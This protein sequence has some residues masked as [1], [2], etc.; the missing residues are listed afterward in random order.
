MCP[1][2]VTGDSMSVSAEGRIIV[3]TRYSGNIGDLEEQKRYIEE[4]GL[5]TGPVIWIP[6]NFQI[7]KRTC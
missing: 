4:I 7:L 5:R 1:A 6:T 3:M 2:A